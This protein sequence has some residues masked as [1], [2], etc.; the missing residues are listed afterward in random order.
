MEHLE[1]KPNRLIHE[2]SPYL[3]E[4]AYNP[5]DWYPWGEEAFRKA[6]RENKPIFLSIG[7]SSCHWCHVF[8]RESFED[9]QVAKFLNENFVSIKVDR[10]ERPDIDE[11]YMKAVMSMTGSGGW[12]LSVFLTP[13]LEPFFGGTYFPPL[14]RSGMPSFIDLARAIARSWKHERKRILE[15]ATSL[16]KALGEMYEFKRAQ[17]TTLDLSVAD[18]CFSLL[19]GSVDEKYGGFG[20][21]PKFPMPSNLFFLMRY[22]KMRSSKLALVM[23]T[24]CLDSML[25]GGIYDQVGGGFH[26]YSTDRYWIVPHF[27]KMLYDNALLIQAYT[28]AFQLTNDVEYERIVRETISWAKRDLL[29]K[30]GGFYSSIDADNS[31]GEGYYYVWTPN[32]LEKALRGQI[33]PI[34]AI[35]RFFSVT[36]E[37]NFEHEKTILTAKSL[38]EAAR[39]NGLDEKYINEL[40]IKSKQVLLSYRDERSKPSTDTKI[41]V[42]WNGLMISALSRASS[43]FD[44]TEYYKLAV[45]AA[46]CL[47]KG[48]DEQNRLYR[49]YKG[50]EFGV[51]GILDDYAFLI[52]GLL[53]LYEAGFDP[54][55]FLKAISLT[56]IMIE[57]FHDDLGGFF[58]SE[59]SKSFIVRVKDAMD[60]ATPSGNSIAALVLSR[61]FEF[62][63]REDFQTLA[64]QTFEV[65]WDSITSLSTSFCQMLVALQ[66]YL[67]GAK[68][69]VISGIPGSENVKELTKAVRTEFLPNSVIIQANSQ[70]EAISPLVRGRM[71]SPTGEAKVFVCSGFSCKLPVTTKDQLLAL[72]REETF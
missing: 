12:P 29:S 18:E 60:G 2:R 1:H 11:I 71:P 16:R 26:R 49:I 42:S 56:E 21:V 43:V 36:S 32:E 15:S 20:D 70:L 25:S 33:E 39:E 69:I 3:L 45:A 63:G 53:D 17:T 6:K 59:E 31:E 7:Y 23:V 30:E 47:L 13:N 4:H 19:A 54:K 8:K 40:I 34:E 51:D 41:I 52:N 72:F 65:F 14:P 9:A 55:Y 68:E 64:K 37:G 28:E 61:L 10:E 48:I 5:V 44:E 46:E 57:K 24:K 38:Q 67:G 50:N 62:T 58:L 27:E 66:F 35:T 22:S